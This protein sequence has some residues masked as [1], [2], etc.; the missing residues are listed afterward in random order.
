MRPFRRAARHRLSIDGP[1]FHRLG[2][3]LL[4]MNWLRSSTKPAFCWLMKCAVAERFCNSLGTM[5]SGMVSMPGDNLVNVSSDGSLATVSQNS[6]EHAALYFACGRSG[7]VAQSMNWRLSPPEIK[8][9]IDNGE[10]K[11]FISQDQYSEV[12]NE[13][14]VEQLDVLRQ[15]GFEMRDDMRGVAVEQFSTHADLV[16]RQC[17]A[18]AA[19]GCDALVNETCKGGFVKETDSLIDGE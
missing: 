9:I 15:H 18:R 2:A 8:K 1:L 13:V 7:L 4:T 14:K 10:P 16:A 19:K 5:S 11:A 17:K 12:I 3:L 6:I